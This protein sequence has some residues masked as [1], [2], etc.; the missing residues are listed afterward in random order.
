M[1]TALADW[2][3]IV[4]LIPDEWLYRDADQI[5]ETEPTLKLRLQI[6]ERY[7]EEPFWRQL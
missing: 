3:R 2:E 7:K 6:L 4:S 1:D 5:D